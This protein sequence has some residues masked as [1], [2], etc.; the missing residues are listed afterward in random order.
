MEEGRDVVKGEEAG[1]EKEQEGKKAVVQALQE[2][3]TE[4]E[5][6]DS[7]KIITELAKFIYNC[8]TEEL[9]RIRTRA[10]LCQIYHHALHDRYCTLPLVA[11]IYM[12]DC[13]YFVQLAIVTYMCTCIPTCI[14]PPPCHAPA[15]SSA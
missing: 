1:E 12:Y 10:M 13:E 14:V 4:V 9:G 11:C 8:P 5:P 15:N 2:L 6:E 3:Q 7:Q